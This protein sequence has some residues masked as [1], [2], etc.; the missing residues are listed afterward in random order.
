MLIDV[1]NLTFSHPFRPPGHEGHIPR[2]VQSIT[3]MVN[4]HHHTIICGDFNI[5][6]RKNPNN[7]VSSQ[8]KVLGF[9]QIIT[10]PTTIKGSCIDHVYVGNSMEAIHKLHYPYYSDH[11][12]IQV[13]MRKKLC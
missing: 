4:P 11:E 5:N 8:L 2:L 12:A 13:V 1:V 3:S 7:S 6:F 10:E 9:R